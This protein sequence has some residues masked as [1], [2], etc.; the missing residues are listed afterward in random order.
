MID[1]NSPPGALA[2]YVL[3]KILEIAL[4]FLRFLLR[5]RSRSHSVDEPQ[6]TKLLLR[7]PLVSDIQFGVFTWKPACCEAHGVG[8][9]T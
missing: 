3:T 9:C 2:A 6:S 4:L 7:G 5:A 8:G 1:C